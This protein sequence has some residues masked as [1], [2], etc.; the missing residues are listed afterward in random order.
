MN[1]LMIVFVWVPLAQY[2]LLLAF[3]FGFAERIDYGKVAMWSLMP[4]MA[5]ILFCRNLD[6][7]IHPPENHE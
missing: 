6:I 3:F 2:A 5:A 7:F 1:V 4:F